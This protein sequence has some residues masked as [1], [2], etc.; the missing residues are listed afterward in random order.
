MEYQE[1]AAGMQMP[2]LGFGTYF[3]SQRL[4]LNLTITPAK[5]LNTPLGY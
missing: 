2:M 3:L 5:R 1:I 4:I